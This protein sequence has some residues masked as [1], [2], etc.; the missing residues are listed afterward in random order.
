MA[1]AEIRYTTDGN[2]A[3]RSSALYRGEFQLP[4]TAGGVLVTARVF[5]A[6]GRASPARAARFTRATYRPAESIPGTAVA[7]GLRFEH[8]EGNIRSAR[9]LDALT[10]VR[11]GVV[12]SVS[13]RGEPRPE[14]YGMRFRGHLRVPEDALYTFSL[15]SDDGSTL[16]IGDAVVVENDGAHGPVEKSGMIAL[17]AGL[18]PVTIRYFQGGGGAVLELRYRVGD[19]AWLS[20]PNSWLVHR[21]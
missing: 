17:R 1:D 11:Q 4:L 8:Y 20:V 5:T 6:E 7:P 3:T 15:T 10:P 16:A 21:R 18:H 2:D 12:D 14:R 13:P 9:G 19:G